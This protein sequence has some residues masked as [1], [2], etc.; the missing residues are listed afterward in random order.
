MYEQCVREMLYPFPSPRL[1]AACPHGQAIL[2]DA[3]KR[4]VPGGIQAELPFDRQA[5]PVQGGTP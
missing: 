2:L 3:M 1:C 5:R 4:R